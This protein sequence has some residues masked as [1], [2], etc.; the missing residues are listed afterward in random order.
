MNQTF[1]PVFAFKKILG[2]EGAQRV[3]SGLFCHPILWELISFEN[4]FTSAASLFGTD[5]ENW[6][7]KNIIF[8]IDKLV[9]PNKSVTKF[10]QKNKY[11]DVCK[12]IHGISE[13]I[14]EITDK[15]KNNESWENILQDLQWDVINRHEISR[16]WGMVFSIIL[17]DQN[18][19]NE[20]E[21]TL[22]KESDSENLLLASLLILYHNKMWISDFLSGNIEFFINNPNT[23]KELVLNL[24]MIGG[25]NVAHQL[26]EELLGNPN[27]TNEIINCENSC[28]S[29]ENQFDKIKKLNDFRFLAFFIKDTEKTELFESLAKDILEKSFI[30]KPVKLYGQEIDL[31]IGDFLSLENYFS[32]GSYNSAIVNN[33]NSKILRDLILAFKTADSDAATAREICR[34]FL[35]EVKEVGINGVIFSPQYGY[36]I[37]PIDI[38]ELLINTGLEYEAILFLEKVICSQPNNL[39]IIKFLAHYSNLLGDHNRAVKYFSNLIAFGNIAREEKIIFCKSLQYLEMWQEALS[40]RNTIN[41]LN[42]NDELE[43][44]IAA[45]KTKNINE[46]KGYIEQLFSKYPKDKIA[47]ALNLLFLQEFQ[48]NS[49]FDNQLK[50]LYKEPNKDIRTIRFI[51]EYLREKGKTEQILLFLNDLPGK[52]KNHPEIQLLIYKAQLEIGDTNTCKSILCDLSKSEAIIHQ[53]VLEEIIHELLKRN[54]YSE[55]KN[56]LDI[57]REKWKL[58]PKIIFAN[59]MI[60]LE[61]KEYLGAKDKISLLLE[62]NVINEDTITVF[63][64]CLLETSLGDFPYRKSIKKLSTDKKRKFQ[65]FYTQLPNHKSNVLINLLNIEICEDDKENNYIELLTNSTSL[66]LKDNWRVP[67]GLGYLY[68]SKKKFDQAIIYFNEA[69]KIV[70]THKVILD[71]LIQAY[72]H[73]KLPEEAIKIIELQSKVNN[74]SLTDLIRYSDFLFEH[75][76]FNK[77]LEEYPKSRWHAAASRPRTVATQ[78]LHRPTRNRHGADRKCVR[79]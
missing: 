3:S 26:V 13:S 51:E 67:F 1:N 71:L 2:E 33:N 18:E 56:L 64:C 59:S 21:K 37:D 73:L 48:E 74:L 6:T 17:T 20:L 47:K 25:Q 55:A 35:G 50:A 28:F 34:R 23:I 10:D 42:I 69:I 38:A 5:L 76:E 19:R 44:V 58:S 49:N 57:Y 43:L 75:N 78:P 9:D 14:Q 65:E 8:N 15:R 16:K 46:L 61:E 12:E 60:L 4:F 40:I 79:G 32:I 63:G 7:P 53:E 70:P 52:Y 62:D 31:D 54:L 77:F 72:S 39:L 30:K 45:H 24:E 22:I 68:F 27:F 11:Q 41:L 36:L 66:E 29:T